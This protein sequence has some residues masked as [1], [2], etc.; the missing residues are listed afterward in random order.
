MNP[1]FIVL[2]ILTILTFTIGL[3]LKLED[4]KLLL[5]RPLPMLIGL[6]GQL[7]VL[8]A[9]AFIIAMLA[10]LPEVFFIGLVLV[11]LCPGGSS[12][13]IFTYLAKGDVA[14]SV[15]MTAIS[16]IVTIFTLP[17]LLSLAIFYVHQSAYENFEFGQVK[18]NLGN[19]IVQNLVLM[20][21]PIILGTLTQ[22]YFKKA[23]LI[24]ER[25]LSKLAFPCLIFLASMFFI[26][27]YHNISSSLDKLGLCVLTLVVI[28][29]IISSL[30]SSMFKQDSKVKRTIVIEVAMQNAAQAIAIASSP[31]VFN[32]ET[33]TF[34]AIIYALF[35]N[36]V[37]IAYVGVFLIKDKKV[38]L[39]CD[40]N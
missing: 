6:F 31:F 25:V 37:L 2:P 36:V 12:S 32:N 8:P 17:F 20:L 34:P 15:A 19:L 22:R 39:A 1:I 30:L 3:T 23:S 26:K 33:M 14:L 40:H 10:N 29:L 13:N 21:V 9:I 35:M 16:S 24:L 27:H 18:F 38:T 11:A 5:K 7:I 28:A 4:F